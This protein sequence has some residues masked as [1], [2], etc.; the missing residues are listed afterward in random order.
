[1]I[2]LKREKAKD[3]CS[4]GEDLRGSLGVLGKQVMYQVQSLRVLREGVNSLRDRNEIV[5]QKLLDQS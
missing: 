2:L 3:E 5:I 1:M 4:K